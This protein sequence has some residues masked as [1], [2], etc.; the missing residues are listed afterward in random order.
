MGRLLEAV[1]ADAHLVLLGDPDQLASVEAGVVLADIVGPTRSAPAPVASERASTDAPPD[2]AG[3]IEDCV[4]LL[5]TNH[6]FSGAIFELADAVRAGEA[7]RAIEVLG[8]GDPALEWIAEQAGLHTTADQF[9]EQLS[10]GHGR[11]LVEAA[12]SADPAVALRTGEDFRVLC[13]HRRGPA[14]A[15]WWNNRIEQI[16]AQDAGAGNGLGLLRGPTSHRDR[17]R[18]RDATIQRG[19]RGCNATRRRRRRSRLSA[20]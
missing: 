4:V 16:V 13:A 11:R 14:G 8:S 2:P 17:Q 12:R 10:L 1:R 15:S 6:R 20:G 19:C 9:L 18:L 5:R 3:G 7:D